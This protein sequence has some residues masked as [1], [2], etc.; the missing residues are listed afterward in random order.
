MTLTMADKWT[1]NRVKK[2]KKKVSI[3]D[4]YIQICITVLDM[5]TRHLEK[6]KGV[7]YTT[8]QGKDVKERASPESRFLLYWRRMPGLSLM[9]VTYTSKTCEIFECHLNWS[10]QPINRQMLPCE[11]GKQLV[12]YKQKTATKLPPK[13]MLSMCDKICPEMQCGFK[14][15]QCHACIILLLLK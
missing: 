4:A 10:T 2:R 7:H 9:A 14:V 5:M 1:F 11:R 3:D 6:N 13:A 15:K 12:R 8:S